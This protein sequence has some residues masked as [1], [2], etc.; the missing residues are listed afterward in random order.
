MPERRRPTIRSLVRSRRPPSPENDA[1]LGDDAATTDAA[2]PTTSAS[3]IVDSAVYVDGD[4]VAS[5]DSLAE[6]YERAPSTARRHGVDRAV[7]ARG[8]RGRLAGS[9]VPAPR[10]R[11]RG[12]HRR[13]PAPEARALRRHPVRR[14]PPARYLD[15]TEE[16]EF[17]EVHVFVGP[18]FVLTVRHSEAP[19]FGAVRRRLESEPDLLRRGPE[20]V[21]YAILD[22]VVDGYYPVVA[23]LGERHRRDRSRGVQ[24]RPAGVATH[25]RAVPRGHPSS[26]GRP[27]R[28]P[29]CC[30][31]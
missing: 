9:G 15:E 17:G 3:R 26:S 22:R 31:R 25:L 14:A 20:A 21:L 29:R 10:A 11:R 16:V 27:G 18:D 13:P 4:R 1:T 8:A 19:D 23:G 30:P 12:R 2:A 7:P 5:P 28:S 6:T 24:R